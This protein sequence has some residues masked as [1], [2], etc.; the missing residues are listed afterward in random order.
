MPI[1]QQAAAV[2]KPPAAGGSLASRWNGGRAGVCCPG[3][4]PG[5]AAGAETSQLPA[6]AGE[7]KRE[8][9]REKMYRSAARIGSD[10]RKM[11]LN[12]CCEAAYRNYSF[13]TLHCSLD[14][15]CPA[16]CAEVKQLPQGREK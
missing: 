14:L 5:L 3:M 8:E 9:R 6:G 4:I 7:V 12:P 2:G 11:H 15:P 10:G 13:F 1:I 16:A